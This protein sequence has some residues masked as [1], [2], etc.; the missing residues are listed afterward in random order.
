MSSLEEAEQITSEEKVALFRQNLDSAEMM[1][2][3]HA[4]NLETW[5]D[6]LDFALGK[7]DK[8]QWMVRPFG[9]YTS[10]CK[11]IFFFAL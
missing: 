7:Q 8:I 2:Y 4:F 6:E 5:S 11:S 10:E 3:V 9:S 1:V